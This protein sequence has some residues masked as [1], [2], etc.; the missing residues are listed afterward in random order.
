MEYAMMIG[1]AFALDLL[2]GDP[3]W[4][5]HPV[6]L[7]GKAIRFSETNIRKMVR[8]EFAGGILLAAVIAVLSFILPYGI[9]YAAEKLSGGLSFI[10]ETFFCYQIFAAKSLK[11]ASMNVY[12][13][14]VKRNIAGA[15]KNLS[16]IVGRDTQ[17]LDQKGIIRAAV[18]T[19]AENTTDGVIAPLLYMALGGAPLAFLYKAVNTM[20][21][22]IGYKNERYI[23]FGRCAA[24][25]DDIANFIPARIAAV[26]MILASALLR[27]DAGN[28][29]KIFIRD[30]YNHKSPNSAQTES[31]CAGALGVRLAGDAYYFGKLVRKPFIGDALREIEP[32]D[33][34]TANKLMMLTSAIAVVIVLCIRGRI[35]MSF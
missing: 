22:M 2:F 16:F 30:R 18:E 1:I 8:N 3:R 12:Y 20:D 11:T 17:A 4:L 28:A 5:P 29:A 31:V 26:I 21:S 15:R 13:P 6:C 32:N 27:L 7:I 34:I 10:I 35:W 25:L 19:I 24:R 23:R 14:L 33:I 9:L